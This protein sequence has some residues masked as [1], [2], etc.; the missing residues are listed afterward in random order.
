MGEARLEIQHHGPGPWP[1]T[2]AQL[3]RIERKLDRL[4]ALLDPMGGGDDD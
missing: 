4:I 1:D 3:N 2:L